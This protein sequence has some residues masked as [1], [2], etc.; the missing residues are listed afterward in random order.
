[1]GHRVYSGS[2]FTH[3]LGGL[4]TRLQRG[5]TR[6]YNTPKIWVDKRNWQES[7][8]YPQKEAKKKNRLEPL[9]STR[10]FSVFHLPLDVSVS[11]RW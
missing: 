3:Y 2:H 9:S 8:N 7:Q 4:L 10:Y 5:P 11:S 1:M 6:I